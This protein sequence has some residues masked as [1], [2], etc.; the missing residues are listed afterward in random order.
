MSSGRERFDSDRAEEDTMDG[1]G[2]FDTYTEFWRDVERAREDIYFAQKDRELIAKLREKDQKELEQA[3][4][5]L[6]AMRCPR[7][8]RKLAETTYRKVRIDRCSG[9]RGVWLDTGELETLAPEEHES[10]LG[11]LL[12]G[13][14]GLGEQDRAG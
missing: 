3:I 13:M 7:C 10:W 11:G 2:K 8:G 9:C 5:E 14:T 1:R 12:R 4:L 6:C